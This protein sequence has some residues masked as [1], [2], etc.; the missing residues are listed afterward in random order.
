MRSA[1]SFSTEPTILAAVASPTSPT[2]LD[3]S[4]TSNSTATMTMKPR[5]APPEIALGSRPIAWPT[6]SGAATVRTAIRMR[7]STPTASVRGSS[8]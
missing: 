2:T 3:S 5:S 8:L 6:R 7:E 4:S 1:V